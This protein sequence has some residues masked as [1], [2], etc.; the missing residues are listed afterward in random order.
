M[1]S[2]QQ[3]LETGGGDY[4]GG[5]AATRRLRRR[6]IIAHLIILIPFA[7][8]SAAAIATLDFAP[9]AL[10]LAGVV[11]LL[12]FG[13]IA[14][15]WR[16]VTGQLFHPYLLFVASA[17]LFHDGE[18]ILYSVGWEDSILR[19]IYPDHQL[20]LGIVLVLLGLWAFHFGGLLCATPKTTLLRPDVEEEEA[21]RWV[22]WGMMLIAAVPLFLVMRS[23]IGLRSHEAYI[24]LYQQE[25]RSGL[26]N[27][28]LALSDFF[29]PGALFV[30]AGARQKWLQLSCAAIAIVCVTLAWLSL[31]VRSTAAMPLISATWLFHTRAKRLPAWLL[32]G[33]G[34]LMV[35]LIFPLVGVIRN[36]SGEHTVVESVQQAYESLQNPFA[37]SIEEFGGSLRPVIDTLALAPAARPFGYGI[38]YAHALL[39]VVPNFISF[40]HFDLPLGQAGTWYTETIDPE[41]ALIGGG[42]G[43]SFIAEAYLEGGWIGATVWLFLIGAAI[44]K[45]SCWGSSSRNAA[46]AAAVA[47]WWVVLLHFPRGASEGYVRQLLWWSIAPYFVSLL[48]KRRIGGDIAVRESDGSDWH[49]KRGRDAASAEGG[50][51]ALPR[52]LRRFH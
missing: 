46:A 49:T 43:Y 36:D 11:L 13:W 27:L 12:E 52:T 32:I 15:S 9:L 35:G 8:Y 31:G 40:L 26:E 18:L 3:S 6:A 33:V 22:G 20:L 41:Y 4:A 30:I 42:W 51:V 39:N 25:A 19:G 14:W 34:T 50:P 17:V 10:R 48:I 7:V 37:S 47:A 29:I 1:I 21:T 23:S 24:A 44:S 28:Q 45:F 2:E 16:W 5:V 38:G